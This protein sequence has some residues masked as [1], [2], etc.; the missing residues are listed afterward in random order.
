MKKTLLTIFIFFSLFLVSAGLGLL[1][2]QRLF[3]KAIPLRLNQQQEKEITL[4][5]LKYAIPNLKNLEY[6]QGPLVI[7]ELLDHQS[8]YDSYIFS[9][10]SQDKKITGQLNIPSQEIRGTIVM[11]RGYVPLEIYSTGV[12]TKN[13]A[14]A[15]ATH[16]Y[17][18]LAPD[19]L[20]F[21]GSEAEPTDSWEARFI[22]PV[23]IIDLIKSLQANNWQIS[24]T[25]P[26]ANSWGIK[27]ENLQLP[28]NH[29]GIWAHSNGGQIA[30]TVLEALQEPIPT[31]LWAPVTAPFPYSVLFFSDE[32]E[33][34][35]KAM[36]KWL[37]LFEKDY[38]VFDFSLTK[39]LDLLSG[40]I[41]IHHGTNDDAA[42]IT[43]SSEFEDKI[44]VENKRRLNL[45]KELKTAT[46]S[47]QIDQI[48]SQILDPIEFTLFS[49]PGADHNMQPVWNNVMEKNL[50]FFGQNLK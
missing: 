49:Y 27:L 16:G 21:G 2:F 18:T 3:N 37:S 46:D 36:R 48:K 22:K 17:L 42:L 20:G 4:P 1:L 28:E 9:Y 31:T 24:N 33:D 23:N 25:N 30:L 26:E 8:S 10:I 38:D 45:Q 29:L 12:G 47:S 5:L 34:E 43:W 32:V 14:A 15:L 6:Q 35:G 39:H 11:I 50:I 7:E 41:Q 44:K 13:A 40:K 19:F